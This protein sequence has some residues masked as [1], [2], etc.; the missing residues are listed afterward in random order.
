MRIKKKT[1]IATSFI[2][3]ILAFIILLSESKRNQ[4]NYYDIS[5]ILRS[6]NSEDIERIKAGMEQAASEENINLNYV[7]LI[8]DNHINNQK[9]LIGKELE[10]NIDGIIIA[11]A[12]YEKL[13]SYVE[14]INKKIPVVLFNSNINTKENIEYVSCDNYYLGKSL[15]AEVIRNGNTR[16]ELKILKTSLDSS[17][18]NEMIKGFEEEMLTV[19]NNIEIIELS[20]DMDKE[21]ETLIKSSYEKAIVT[22]E[23]NILA[24]IGKSKKYLGKEKGKFNEIYG[25]GSSNLIISLVEENIINGIAVPNEFNLGYISIKKIVASIEKEDLSYGIIDSIIINSENMYSK[26]NQRRLFPITK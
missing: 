10:K 11:P 24:M 7:T 14:E 18:I 12:D 1:M 21:I 6:K 9:E 4:I 17:N 22:F 3:L 23:P 15:A 8:E 19:N 5:V 2:L 26:E 25:V 13:T 20:K 16:S